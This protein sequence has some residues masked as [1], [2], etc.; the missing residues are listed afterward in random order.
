MPGNSVC[1]KVALVSTDHCSSFDLSYDEVGSDNWFKMD[2]HNM[3]LPTM[4]AAMTHGSLPSPLN[5]TAIKI[6]FKL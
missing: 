5:T 4:I 3:L 6:G 1:F 2:A